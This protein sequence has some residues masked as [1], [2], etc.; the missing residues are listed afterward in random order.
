M[1]Y[2][3][4]II[5]IMALSY[6]ICQKMG[7]YSCIRIK[8]LSIPEK[9]KTS[10]NGE[11]MILILY[12]NAYANCSSGNIIYSLRGDQNLTVIVPN[13]FSSNDIENLKR[14]FSLK[15]QIIKGGQKTEQILRDFAKCRKWKI[16][17]HKVIIYSK[18]NKI[19]N[20]KKF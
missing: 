17:E 20:F 11:N 9:M 10:D 15:G 1:K 19:I 6:L 4:V 13:D 5:I 8:I 7:Y 3:V 18:G 2:I 14:K 12:G 16:W